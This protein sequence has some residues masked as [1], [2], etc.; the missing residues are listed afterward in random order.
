MQALKQLM[1]IDYFV[2]RLGLVS[3]WLAAVSFSRKLRPWFQWTC[4][5]SGKQT[6]EGTKHAREYTTGNH[7]ITGIRG[8]EIL[9]YLWGYQGLE[10]SWKSGNISRKEMEEDIKTKKTN[11]AWIKRFRT[12]VLPMVWRQQHLSPYVILRHCLSY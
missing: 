3:T 4:V 12:C 6:H 7:N 10:L 9:Q 8:L 1:N 2:H 11:K 5:Q